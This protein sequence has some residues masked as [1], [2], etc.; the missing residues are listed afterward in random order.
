M[1]KFLV[2]LFILIILAGVALFFGWA[3]R[4]VP[5]DGYGLIRSKSH[6]VY[7]NLIIPG[8]FK[9]LWYKLIPTNTET[10]VFHLKTV[11]RTFSARNTLPSGK[12]YAA[13]T[14]IDDDFNWEISASFSFRVRHT[15]LIPLAN[16]G[17]I[18]SQEDLA[19]YESDLTAQIEAAILRRISTGQE[20]S[21][22][23]E[24]LL[25]DGDSAELVQTIQQEFP[26]IENVAI[27]VKTAVI[28]NFALYNQARE[29]YNDYLALQKEHISG[30]AGEK[31]ATQVESYRRFDE[32]EQYG[33]LLTKYPILLE[34]LKIKQ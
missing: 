25:K 28:P 33:L 22:P 7:P 2:F 23:I 10:T 19:R 21:G 12:T 8:E 24:S 16:A 3:Q 34:Y 11:D 13:F 1:K 14:G 4:G 32:L 15:A 6:G 17:T 9:W 29:V 20:N 31:A 26:T 27:R 5:P 30:L 18:S